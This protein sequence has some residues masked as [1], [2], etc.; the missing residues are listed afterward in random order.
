MK[1]LILL[2]LFSPLVSFGQ[3][4][5]ETKYN[6]PEGF[7]RVYND[8]YSKFLRQ[9]PLKENNRVKFYN[10]GEKT[11]NDI[12]DAVFDYDIGK[13]DLHQCADAVLYMRA[14]FLFKQGLTENLYYNFVSGFK[15][16]YSDYM[17]H[18]YKIEGNN[19]S[20]VSRNN[21]LKDNPETLRKWLRQIYSYANTWSIDKYDSSPVDILQM[22]PGDFF[23]VSNPPPATG[24]AINVVDVVVNKTNNKK[25]YMLSQSYMPAQETHI[26]INPLN[27]G[28]W[29]ALDEF[30]DIVTPEWSFTVNQ[31][32][33]FNN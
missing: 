17:T 30:K 23:I 29:Y 11:N 20:L 5:I 15:A 2:L 18:Y 25:M 21:I 1:K 10:G 3:L 9:F 26:L 8:G 22:K 12:W 4:N 32:K 13:G 28:V 19:V 14:N 16:K 7:E 24:H 31:L 27:G 6:P 33:R